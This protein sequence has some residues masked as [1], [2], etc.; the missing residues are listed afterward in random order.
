MA[1]SQ[2]LRNKQ[3]GLKRPHL[4]E[5]RRDI[6]VDDLRQVFQKQVGDPLLDGG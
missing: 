2:E 6:D 3:H 5:Q 4:R 1:P